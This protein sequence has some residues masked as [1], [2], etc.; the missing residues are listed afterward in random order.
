MGGGASEAGYALVAAVASIGLLATIA[1]T[2]LQANSA[3]MSAASAEIG[4]AN[5]EA[6]AEAGLALALHDL[7]SSVGGDLPLDGR[8][9]HYSFGGADLAVSIEDEQGKIPLNALEEEDVRNLLAVLGLSGDRLDIA[10]DSFLDWQD[11][12]DDVRPNGAE[13]PFYVTQGIRPRNGALRSVDEVAMIRGFDSAL[14]R[15]L[16][17]VATV[18]FGKG[19]FRPDRASPTAIRVMMGETASAIDLINRERVLKGQEVALSADGAKTLTGR[20]FSIHVIATQ[21]DGSRAVLRQIAV[22]TGRP[23]RPYVLYEHY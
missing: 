13:A 12:D 16:K 2:I 5:A 4:R 14:A 21:H 15:Q 22:L 1:I 19:S 6:A 8:V 11:D 3:S 7:P 18:H 9:R 17:D 10:T 20:P 23:D